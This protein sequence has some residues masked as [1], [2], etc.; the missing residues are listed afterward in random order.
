MKVCP[1]C[2]S[3]RM[4]QSHARTPSELFFRDRLGYHFYRCLQCDWRGKGKPGNKSD[5]LN[6]M[7]GRWKVMAIYASA[8]MLV[9]LLVFV[10]IGVGDTALPP[11]PQ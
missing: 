6:S 10:V 2:T 11:P 7:A 5:K 8:V 1:K 3:L 4:R 9:L